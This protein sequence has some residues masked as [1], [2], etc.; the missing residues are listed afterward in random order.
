M[1]AH[2][3]AVPFT[4]PGLPS[5]GGWR[6]VLDS[7]EPAL[8]SGM[9]ALPPAQSYDLPGRA[10]VVLLADRAPDEAAGAGEAQSAPAEVMAT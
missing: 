7:S 4:L 3:E 8:A 6:R 1:N 9:P 2:D 5:I 10:L